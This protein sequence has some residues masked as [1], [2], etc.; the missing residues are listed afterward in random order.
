MNTKEQELIAMSERAKLSHVS[1]EEQIAT[2]TAK[3]VEACLLLRRGYK[4]HTHDEL[5]PEQAEDHQKKVRAFLDGVVVRGGKMERPAPR[6]SLDARAA[7]G[8][9]V[10]LA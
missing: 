6:P 5:Y 3:L 9:G 7:E 10:V 4:I 2:L 8:G 1:Q